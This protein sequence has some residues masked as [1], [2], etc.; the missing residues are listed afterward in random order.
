MQIR[1]SGTNHEHA[2]ARAEAT[3]CKVDRTHGFAEHPPTYLL[4]RVL[5]TVGTLSAYASGNP[6]ASDRDE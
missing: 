2:P 1:E 5:A 6:I 3:G 4:S